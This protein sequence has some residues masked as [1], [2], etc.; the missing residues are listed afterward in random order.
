MPFGLNYYTVNIAAGVVTPQAIG[1]DLDWNYEP[2]Q[3]RRYTAQLAA[4]G[5]T[6]LMEAT[7]DGQ[8]WWPLAAAYTGA[9]TPF[10]G[11]VVG[12]V[13]RIRATK[14]GTAGAAVVT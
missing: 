10:N 3:V 8:N 9:T 4:A 2:N 13:R 6:I 12:P 11:T 7:L 5:D 14:S 1:G